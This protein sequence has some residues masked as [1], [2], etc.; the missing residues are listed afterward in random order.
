MI[1]SALVWSS[2]TDVDLSHDLQHARIFVSIYGNKDAKAKA[3]GRF[4]G[5]G[6]ILFGANSVNASVSDVP[7][8]WSS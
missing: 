2:V 3:Y 4:K 5:S 1:G 6:R 8:K 7:P